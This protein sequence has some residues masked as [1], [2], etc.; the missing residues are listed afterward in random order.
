MARLTRPATHTATYRRVQDEVTQ[1]HAQRERLYDD[2]EN[3]LKKVNGREASVVAFFTSFLYPVIIEDR[4]ADILEEMLQNTNLSGKDL[5]LL[6]NSPGGDA[7]AAE[8]IVNICRSYS[9]S[10]NFSVIVPKMAKSAA[11]MICFGAETIGMSA[12]SEL[13]PIDPQMPIFDADG[14]LLRFQAGHEIIE[15]YERLMTMASRTKGRLEPY[16]EQLARYDAREIRL[17]RSQQQ[18][19]ESVALRCLG[20]GCFRGS[21]TQSIRRRIKPFLDPNY[22]KSHGRPIY[23]DVAV[24]S[25]LNVVQHDLRS[26]LW[27]AVWHLYVRLDHILSTHAAKVVE[28]VRDAYSMGVVQ[29]RP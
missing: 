16:L 12:T 26:D 13:G 3:H 15:S 14:N 27:R 25:K 21:S 2:I 6:L 22:T 9:D 7:L 19:S 20:S 24:R 5:V 29:H 10:G 17:I 23:R 8:R 1:G 11:T 28:S 18:L 4:D